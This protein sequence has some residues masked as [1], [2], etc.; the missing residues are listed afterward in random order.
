MLDED[1]ADIVG[2]GTPSTQISEYWNG[3][4]NWYSPTEIGEKVYVDKS[5]KGIT[6]K[7]LEK[8]SAKILPANRTVL[9]TSRAGIGHMA[10]LSKDGCTNQGFQSFIVKDNYDT[11]FLYSSGLLKKKQPAP[12]SERPSNIKKEDRHHFQIISA[13]ALLISLFC[14]LD[15]NDRRSGISIVQVAHCD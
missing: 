10:I 3:D 4:I 9:F 6:Q 14:A 11:Y 7:G 12:V 5:E 13:T 8:S 2:G 1:I 15:G